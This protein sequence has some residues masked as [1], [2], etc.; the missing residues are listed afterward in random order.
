MV[1]ATEP[2]ASIT[3]AAL[4]AI[5]G[6]SGAD[7]SPSM[8][9]PTPTPSAASA[10]LTATGEPLPA[11]R[12]TRAGFAPAITFELDGSWEA[13]QLADGFFDVQH[14]PG[15][16]DVIAVQFAR[17]SG[18]FG[19]QRAERSSG[20]DAAST[21]CG[22]IPGWSSSRAATRASAVWTGLRSRS[23]TPASRTPA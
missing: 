4:L 10:N 13:V 11:G 1:D 2:P 18:M 7:P 14:D 8:S 12:Y 5:S 23:R 3:M 20:A 15:S 22:P 9:D 6:C 19:A 17:P 16:Q 21:P